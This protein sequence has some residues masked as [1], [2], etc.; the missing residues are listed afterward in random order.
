VAG[1]LEVDVGRAKLE[2]AEVNML[3][4]VTLDAKVGDGP[5]V[6]AK[7]LVVL[8]DGTGFSVEAEVEVDV[9]GDAKVT[10]EVKPMVPPP[11]L[12]APPGPAQI[13]P[14]GQQPYSSFVPRL[15][16]AV[17]GQPPDWSGQQVQV[18]SMQP[19]PQSF[20]PWSEHGRR[21]F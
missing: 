6:E 9:E 16:N 2:S 7:V 11:I 20:I 1:L 19:D 8:G 4:K 18:G 3:G 12:V 10:V 21:V 14:S 5:E 13:S 17:G 15:Q